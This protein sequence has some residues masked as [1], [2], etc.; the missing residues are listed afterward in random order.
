MVFWSAMLAATIGVAVLENRNVQ[1]SVKLEGALFWCFGAMMV[2]F[3]VLR[4]I[5]IAP[6]DQAYVEIYNTVCSTLN[7]GQWVQGTRDW[8]WYSLVGI[9]KSF[10]PEPRAML[11]IAGLALAMKLWVIFRLCS[12]PMMALLLF[13]GVFYQMQDLTAFRVS[14]SLAFFMFAIWIYLKQ[15]R[16]LGGVALVFPGLF[17][18]QALLALGLI[19]APL[20]RQRFW[21]LVLTMVAPFVMLWV[22]GKPSIP[23]FLMKPEDM[24]SA[25][26]VQQGLDSYISGYAAGVFQQDKLIPWSLYPL[27]GLGLW[28]AKDVFIRNRDLY[29][30]VAASMAI[31]C[32]LLYCFATLTVAQVR[33]FEFF[34]LPMVLLAGE[35]KRTWL[36]LVFV[37]TVSGAYVIRFNV[38]HPLII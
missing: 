23:T 7:C 22:F 31:G 24:L 15:S 17:H 32:G 19:V 6:D 3:A 36:T 26:A 8:G 10:W 9:L 18:K 28:L 1:I 4:P 30:I 2:F 33:F 13:T 11:L 35:V 29:S 5:G 16:L 34:M 25:Q 20:F 37:A 21:F 14:S 38:L 27:A 12:R